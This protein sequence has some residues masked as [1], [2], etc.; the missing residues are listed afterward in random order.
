MRP[1]GSMLVLGALTLTL[2]ATAAADAAVST[3]ARSVRC[4]VDVEID[5]AAPRPLCMVLNVRARPKRLLVRA[6]TACRLLGGRVQGGAR[7]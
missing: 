2:L 6:R 7:S 1:I 4:C 3:R 5:G